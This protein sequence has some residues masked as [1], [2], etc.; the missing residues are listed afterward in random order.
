MPCWYLRTSLHCSEV[1][2]GAGKEWLCMGNDNLNRY[3]LVSMYK[4]NLY[5]SLR[6]ICSAYV[7]T[8]DLDHASNMYD[9]HKTQVWAALPPR[10]WAI[11]KGNSV[12]ETTLLIEIVGSQNCNCIICAVRLDCCHVGI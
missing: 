9:K 12:Q 2:A 11:M 7:L 10:L 1:R 8:C 6:E 4:R 5:L 3:F